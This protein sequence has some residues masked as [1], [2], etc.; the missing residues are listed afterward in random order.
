MPGRTSAGLYLDVPA[1]GPPSAGVTAARSSARSGR[2]RSRR[3]GRFLA[4]MREGN[5]DD[6][7]ASR[8][9]C[10]TGGEET[11]GRPGSRTAGAWLTSRLLAVR[12]LAARVLPRRRRRGSHRPCGAAAWRAGGVPAGPVRQGGLHAGGAGLA[13]AVGCCP[14]CGGELDELGAAVVRVRDA[15]RVAG[16]LEP[17]YLP[18]DVRGLHP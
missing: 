7:W 17:L 2:G 9:R 16:L 11:P 8:A 1:H 15:V 6:A 13:D 14:A 18:G 5:T 3:F 4:F 10:P 12:A